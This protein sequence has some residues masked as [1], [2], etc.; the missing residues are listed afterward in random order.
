MGRMPGEDMRE[1]KIDLVSQVDR[2][3]AKIGETGAKLEKA[4]TAP[5]KLQN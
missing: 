2:P 5:S 3:P 4:E 1:K